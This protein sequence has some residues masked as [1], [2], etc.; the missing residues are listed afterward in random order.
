[1]TTNSM[2]TRGSRDGN[3]RRL[4]AARSHRSHSARLSPRYR[5]GTSPSQR[6]E[7]HGASTLGDRNIH[8]GKAAARP[9]QRARRNPPAADDDEPAPF[10]LL[11]LLHGAGGNGEGMLRRLGTA[12]DE[13][14]V[15]VLAPDS[16]DATWDAVRAG[17]GR[18][19][20]FLDSALE[21]A[22][23]TVAGRPGA[24]CRRRVL[25]WRHLCSLAWAHQWRSVPPCDRLL[26]RLPGRWS[27]AWKAAA[28]HLAWDDRSGSA[29]RELQSRDRARSADAGLR[30]HVPGIRWRAHDSARHCRDAMRWA[31]AM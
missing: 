3:L 29:D 23:A 27:A 6:R 5:I 14:G 22:F 24:D 30:C 11:V 9:G 12:A 7:T 10:P 8:R 18:D 31:A 26:S 1:M 28:L 13:A 15:A 17:F 20:M 4:P 19:V 2:R 21:R 25:R 16:R